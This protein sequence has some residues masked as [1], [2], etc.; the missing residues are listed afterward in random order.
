M[1]LLIGVLTLGVLILVGQAV[2]A[3]D[4]DPLQATVEISNPAG[5]GGGT[6]SFIQVGNSIRVVG[7]FYGLPP[8]L[9][10]IT[11][12]TVGDCS[13]LFNAAAG[14][15]PAELEQAITSLLVTHFGTLPP[16]QINPDGTGGYEIPPTTIPLQEG[17]TLSIEQLNDSSLVLQIDVNDPTGATPSVFCG[18]VIGPQT[19]AELPSL[20]PDTGITSSVAALVSGAAVALAA[21]TLVSRRRWSG[22]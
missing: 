9:H 14:I 16:V 8:G 4:T 7:T 15:S 1:K 5:Q 13:A 6:L 10:D 11:L 20:L 2:H 12:G 17:S 21:G 19:L 18:V 22:W 3:Q